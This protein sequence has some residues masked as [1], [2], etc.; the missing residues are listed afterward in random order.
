MN[1][2]DTPSSA[3][4][5]QRFETLVAS[6]L[7]GLREQDLRIFLCE[8]KPVTVGT[9][10]GHTVS[11]RI[12]GLERREGG[13]QRDS[14]YLEIPVDAIPLPSETPESGVVYLS[15]SYLRE[16]DLLAAF[17]PNLSIGNRYRPAGLAKRTG[18]PVPPVFDKVA[19]ALQHNYFR[20][21]T[22]EDRLPAEVTECRLLFARG[23]WHP[24]V[25]NLTQGV[26]ADLKWVPA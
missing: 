8:Q 17:E 14:R 24:Q 4:A 18:K 19:Q 20:V 6:I 9:L 25:D 3:P 22:D 7:G 16:H 2:N 26:V 23:N 5:D 15:F 1:T 12:E 13:N 10:K 21:A 11:F